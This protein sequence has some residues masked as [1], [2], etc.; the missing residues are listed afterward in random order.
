M[1]GPQLVPVPP[2]EPKGAPHQRAK[3][4]VNVH[5]DPSQKTPRTFMGGR[6]T[7]QGRLKLLDPASGETIDVGWDSHFMQ[8]LI[9]QGVT[10]DQLMPV[11][12][13]SFKNDTASEALIAARIQS[14]ERTQRELLDSVLRARRELKTHDS[15]KRE[16]RN[17]LSASAEKLL[18]VERVDADEQLNQE[19]EHMQKVLDAA[20]RRIAREAAMDRDHEIRAREMIAQVCT[21]ANPVVA[22]GLRPP[23]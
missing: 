3:V 15:A 21:L 1:A 20:Y 14:W 6:V 10:L 17:A 9:T 11:D 5:L 18:H 12:K 7:E 8:A 16:V 4:I 19:K 13:S 22:A 2:S 23:K